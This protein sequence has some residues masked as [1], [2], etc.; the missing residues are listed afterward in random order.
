MPRIT[1]RGFL[2]TTCCA[3]A[4]AGVAASSLNR[5]GMMSAY[6]QGTDYKALVGIFMFGGNDANNMIIPYEQQ[7]LYQLRPTARQPRSEAE[8]AVA[9][10]ARKPQFA[11]RLSSHVR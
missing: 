4:A 5:L 6:A 7:R 8:L 2:R 9:H 11:I 10:S 1:R 3:A